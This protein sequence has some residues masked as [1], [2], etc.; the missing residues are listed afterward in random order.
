MPTIL[1]ALG[2]A[3]VSDPTLWTGQEMIDDPCIGPLTKDESSWLPVSPIDPDHRYVRIDV[4]PMTSLVSRSNFEWFFRRW[5]HLPHVT[6]VTYDDACMAR[7]M[8]L[9]LPVAERRL[10]GMNPY[11]T[12]VVMVDADRE[13]PL[14]DG[15]QL[16]ADADRW[17]GALFAQEAID[18]NIY[19]TNREEVI[20]ALWSV[21]KE[22]PAEM[23]KDLVIALL[24]RMGLD[25]ASDDAW[26]FIESV[27]NTTNVRYLYEQAGGDYRVEPDHAI[28]V[29][30]VDPNEAEDNPVALFEY[31]SDIIE[32]ML[33]DPQLRQLYSGLAS[34]RRRR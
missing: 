2:D 12:A 10:F 21:E 32:G 20:E 3:P 24:E 4:M 17:V 27:L 31:D 11:S 9:Q 29:E 25:P 28:Y 34:N 26:D 30:N 22:D 18:P 14:H 8:G 15:Q 23:V 5:G 19:Q 33:R 16:V 13:L 6:L 7:R 1:D